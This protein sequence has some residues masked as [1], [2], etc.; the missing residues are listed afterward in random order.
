MV[1]IS[2]PAVAGIR[3][4]FE[5]PSGSVNFVKPGPLFGSTTMFMFGINFR[6]FAI[7]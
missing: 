5:G 3:R 1:R 2:S 6:K 7:C 4:D